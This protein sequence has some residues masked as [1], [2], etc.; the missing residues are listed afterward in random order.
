M[1]TT[2]KPSAMSAKGGE[3]QNIII[4][5]FFQIETLARVGAAR[6]DAVELTGMDLIDSTNLT[7]VI[8]KIS[9]EIRADLDVLDEE[10]MP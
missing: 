3:V 5:K 8:E 4:G 10:I 1:E 9:K 7:V 2:V 6:M